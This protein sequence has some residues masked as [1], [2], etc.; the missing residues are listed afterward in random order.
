MRL[1]DSR[2]NIGLL[3]QQADISVVFAIYLLT[4]Q[5]HINLLHGIRIHGRYDQQEKL[6]YVYRSHSAHQVNWT[7][8]D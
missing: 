4:I 2:L 6:W 3:H 5:K 1:G 8:E 7:T